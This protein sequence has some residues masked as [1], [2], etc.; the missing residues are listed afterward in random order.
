MPTFKEAY[1]AI[2]DQVIDLTA[3]Y[4]FGATKN[5]ND[6]LSDIGLDEN[7]LA[8]LIANRLNIDAGIQEA[9]FTMIL[10]ANTLEISILYALTT[11]YTHYAIVPDDSTSPAIGDFIFKT[12]TIPSKYLIGTNGEDDTYGVS[13]SYYVYV[14]DGTTITQLDPTVNNGIG[15]F[16]IQT[17]ATAKPVL[18]A[19]FAV[20]SNTSV[21]ATATVAAASIIDGIDLQIDIVD[22]YNNNTVLLEDTSAGSQSVISLLPSTLYGMAQLVYP[23]EDGPN[24]AR[25]KLSNI[26]E[27]TT[28]A[29]GTISSFTF[30]NPSTGAT[31]VTIDTFTT[32]DA[33]TGPSGN[34]VF[35][36]WRYA[37][38]QAGLDNA[39]WAALPTPSSTTVDISDY[40]SKTVYAQ[41]RD[42]TYPTSISAVASAVATAVESSPTDSVFSV[43]EQVIDISEE[44][45]PVATLTILRG[46]YTTGTASVDLTFADGTDGNAAIL[47]THYKI[48]DA[49]LTAEFEDAEAS[50]TIDIPIMFRNL[51]HID[52]VPKKRWFTVTLT[53]PSGSNTIDSSAGICTVNIYGM[54]KTSGLTRI[55]GYHENGQID[56]FNPPVD[57]TRT[58]TT[59][60]L[61]NSTSYSLRDFDMQGLL[62][63]ALMLPQNASTI[64]VKDCRVRNVKR[65]LIRNQPSV[66]SA[67]AIKFINCCFENWNLDLQIGTDLNRVIWL[68][69]HTGETITAIEMLG[70]VARGPGSFAHFQYCGASSK[71][72]WNWFKNT[73]NLQPG[74][75]PDL[76]GNLDLSYKDGRLVHFMESGTGG[77]L[78]IIGNTVWN[79]RGS[80]RSGFELDMIDIQGT[81]GTQE[82]T[83]SYVLR[84]W[85]KG[86]GCNNANKQASPKGII[87]ERLGTTYGYVSV[88]ANQIDRALNGALGG[89]G[90]YNW[91]R[92]NDCYCPANLDDVTESGVA[93]NPFGLSTTQNWQYN[94]VL[95]YQWDPGDYMHLS[96]W[97]IPDTDYQS[98]TGIPADIVTKTAWD[99]GG[100]DTLYDQRHPCLNNGG[101]DD[102]IDTIFSHHNT[103]AGNGILYWDYTNE[104]LSFAAFGET[105]GTPIDIDDGSAYEGGP[106]HNWDK[107]YDI[108]S[109]ESLGIRAFIAPDTLKAIGA[110]KYYKIKCTQLLPT[111]FHAAPYNQTNGWDYADSY[112]GIWVGREYLTGTAPSNA[113][114]TPTLGSSPTEGATTITFTW[115]DESSNGADSYRLY[116]DGVIVA[117]PAQGDY[118]GYV[119]TPPDANPHT[120]QVAS[121]DDDVSPALLSAKSN[122]VIA[123][124]QAAGGGVAL[125]TYDDASWADTAVTLTDQGGGV[126]RF[127]CT[128]NGVGMVQQVVSLTGLGLS[129]ATETTLTFSHDG[130]WV[131]P[132]DQGRVVLADGSTAI[133]DNWTGSGLTLTATKAGSPHSIVDG[134]IN[135][136]DSAQTEYTITFTPTGDT[137]RLLLRVTGPYIN[138]WTE[139]TLVEVSQ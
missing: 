133:S 86:S 3:K 47:N 119:Y 98:V 2:I 62:D 11:S 84:N 39:S 113:P 54:H 28:D 91:V 121:A 31:T 65:S 71:I 57:L 94:N 6:T 42:E 46:N 120:Y 60:T 90:A 30:D 126:W 117:S 80:V 75:P 122:S 8:A 135:C 85:L 82:S 130:H 34:V 108:P 53:N 50:T 97:W 132:E 128:T 63:Y 35:D 136:S 51:G 13:H 79:P 52:G 106:D 32:N 134:G 19:D 111:Q 26:V 9:Q 27:V 25:A 24:S 4:Y 123:Q 58:T 5:K 92:W 14:H 33:G 77:T 22:A 93:L 67:T 59:T 125:E 118:S 68:Y 103:P 129:S 43:Q 124:L 110:D 139:F 137:F 114:D 56:A 116:A 16:D 40:V 1:D 38:T 55:G 70:N 36:Q 104:Q 20:P 37:F 17:I 64:T 12:G 131:N 83:R 18:S 99:N 48:P 127:A 69:K 95:Y 87:L 112:L 29:V 109:S 41:C 96:P 102:G 72:N 66:G 45:Q 15:G 73:M 105:Y 49:S 107:W 115:S 23:I 10:P 21:S 74:V 138:L 89:G 81:A 78:E 88:M 7:Q 76:V 61:A 44:G 101:Y 100:G